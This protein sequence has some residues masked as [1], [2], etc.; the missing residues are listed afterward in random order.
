MSS[1]TQTRTQQLREI[2]LFCNLTI[3]LSRSL[4]L[5]LSLFQSYVT[6]CL[7]SQWTGLLPG[8]LTI[9]TSE[10]IPNGRLFRQAK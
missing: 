5:F 2:I 3:S 1:P 6:Y 4:D 7:L 8:V 9:L 10:N